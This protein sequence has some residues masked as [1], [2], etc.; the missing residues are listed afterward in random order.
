MKKTGP[1]RRA[2]L[3]AALTAL[4]TSVASAAQNVTTIAGSGAAG[5][6]DG[7]ALNATFVLPVAVAYAAT[8]H[9]PDSV[10]I[11]SF[12]NIFVGDFNTGV[13]QI[14]SGVVSTMSLPAPIQLD[15]TSVSTV[16]ADAALHLI[17]VNRDG[18][19]VYEPANGKNA[20]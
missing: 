15:I 7:P 10:A 2:L 13:R 18:I 12:G 16:G 4:A 19:Y 14:K 5:S 11:D 9:L 8:F 6:L 17:I 1:T 3:V 20:F